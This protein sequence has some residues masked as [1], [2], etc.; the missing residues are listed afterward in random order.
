MIEGELSISNEQFIEYALQLQR[1]P[2]C[3]HTAN[4]CYYFGYWYA[5][6]STARLT[7]ACSVLCRTKKFHSPEE[8]IEAWN[9]AGVTR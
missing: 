2:W 8:A 7:D 6:C 4:L 5:E 1:C 3:K 9:R